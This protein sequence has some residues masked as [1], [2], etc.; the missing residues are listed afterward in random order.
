MTSIKADLDKVDCQ[1]K[2][3]NTEALERKLWASHQDERS[4]EDLANI[5]Q[6]MLELS[7]VLNVLRKLCAHKHQV[8]TVNLSR[9]AHRSEGT[10]GGDQQENFKNKYILPLDEFLELVRITLVSYKFN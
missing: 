2:G 4:S 6:D 3:N 7:T 10:R 9:M 5:N 1:G 8:E